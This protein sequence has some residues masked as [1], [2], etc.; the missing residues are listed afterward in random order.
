MSRWS[1]FGLPFDSIDGLIDYLFQ[2]L[3]NSELFAASN[4]ALIE[5]INGPDIDQYVD[6]VKKFL[7]RVLQLHSLMERK[8]DADDMDDCLQICNL[9]VA[10]LQANM[11]SL[12]SITE[13]DDSSQQDISASLTMLLV[14]LCVFTYLCVSV[15]VCL[16]LC[17]CIRAV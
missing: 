11:K 9:L 2:V 5:I 6:T 15:C 3:D 13:E 17:V 16:C 7:A 4:G 12:M 10:T 8:L 1:Q 14:R